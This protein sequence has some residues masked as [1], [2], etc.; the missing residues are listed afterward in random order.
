M[1]SLADRQLGFVS[2]VVES[3]EDEAAMRLNLEALEDAT[4]TFMLQVALATTRE[5]Q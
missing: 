5:G 4:T 3:L 2:W 1:M